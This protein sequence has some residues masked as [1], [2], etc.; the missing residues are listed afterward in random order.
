MAGAACK[1][2]VRPTQRKAGHLVV[3]KAALLPV[4]AIVAAC[5]IGAVT[6]FVDVVFHMA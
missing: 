5:A 3:V 1:R 4:S 6:S 2:L